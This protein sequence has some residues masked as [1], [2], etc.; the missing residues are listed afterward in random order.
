MTAVL[1]GGQKAAILFVIF[2]MLVISFLIGVVAKRRTKNSAQQFIGAT[3]SFGPIAT[4]LSSTAAMASGWMLVGT[5]A[6]VYSYGNI[7][8]IYSYLSFCFALGFIYVGKRMRAIAEVAEIS[9]L[10][11]VLD[12]RYGGSGSTRPLKAFFAVTM[13]LG[14]LSYLASQI[15][16]GSG[17]MSYLFPNWPVLLSCAAVFGIV[18]L[19]VAVGGESAGLLSQ[20]FQ[21]AVMVICGIVFIGFFFFEFGGFGALSSALADSPTVTNAAGV[22]K[23]FS[24]RMMTAFGLDNSGG[25]LSVTYLMMPLIGVA[26]QP[27]CLTRMYAV[28][29]PR[30]LGKTSL[31]SALSQAVVCFSGMSIAFAM[32]HLVSSGVIEPLAK[33]DQLTWTY[34]NYLGFG[35]QLI[36][37]A[38][39]MA[40]IVSSAS[41]YITVGA[42]A[43]AIDLSSA[44]N[45]KM[46][47]AQ[48]I[49]ISRIAIVIVGIGGIFMAALSSETVAIIA[50]LGWGTIV[51]I[52]LPIFVIGC[53]WKKATRKGMT[54]AAFA[55]MVGNVIGLVTTQLM[56]ITYPKG[57][58]WYMWVICIS[59]MI[60][61][62]G[63]LATYNKDSDKVSPG[64][65]AALN[66]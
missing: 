47:D 27:S 35:V 9:T 21:G 61:V 30:N 31:T 44:L 28:K 20:A 38:G 42:N 3:K 25:V 15:S 43:L 5:P 13:F 33:A 26:C 24:P 17:L 37:Y 55:A 45:F 8:A 16:A 2:A 66:L 49:K 23:T 4:G 19:Y 50:S 29:D 1:T 48:K 63:S 22:A 53:A 51:S 57:M 41:M 40:A 46:S 14:C 54:A 39:I 10:G 64:I 59:V 6:N 52:N 65:E 60:G 34:C 12:V 11:D 18:T 7:M 36:C 62:F 58:P 32:I 56:K